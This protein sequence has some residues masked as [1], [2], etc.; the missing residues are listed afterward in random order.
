M[1]WQPIA[2]APRDGTNILIRFGVDGVS[3]AKYIAGIPFPWQ[4]ID[5]QNGISWLINHAK[6][7]PGGPSHWMP[8]PT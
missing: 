1:I 7:N 2:T 4:F 3:Q 5:T 6:D 8:M